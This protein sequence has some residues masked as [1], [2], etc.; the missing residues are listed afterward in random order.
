MMAMRTRS[1][2]GL[3]NPNIPRFSGRVRPRSRKALQPEAGPE[4][5][6]LGGGQEAA[7]PFLRRRETETAPQPAGRGADHAQSYLVAEACAH[8]RAQIA[9]AID[10][11]QFQR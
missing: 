7:G 4:G 6:L 1:L 8:H 10:Q 3:G 5:A 11:A 2:V 9:D